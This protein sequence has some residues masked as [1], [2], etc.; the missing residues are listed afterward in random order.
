M[1]TLGINVQTIASLSLVWTLGWA[2]LSIGNCL[3]EDLAW[4]MRTRRQVSGRFIVPVDGV[5]RLTKPAD[6][7]AIARQ[8]IQGF[9]DTARDE[10]EDQLREGRLSFAVDVDVKDD[11]KMLRQVARS[12]EKGLVEA[13]YKVN[14]TTTLRD[15]ITIEII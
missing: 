1:S 5:S 15:K 9:V 14:I 7:S 3:Y 12:I 6:H 11:L 2:G 8:A 10:I 4:Y 13:G